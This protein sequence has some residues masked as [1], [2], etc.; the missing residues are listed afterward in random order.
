M[1]YLRSES[2]YLDEHLQHTKPLQEKLFIEMKARI[3]ENDSTVPEKRGGYFYYSRYLAGKQYPI[4]CRKQGSLDGVEEILL[5]QNELAEGKLFCSVGAF[6]ISPD[7]SKFVYSVDFG[8]QEIYRLHI[9]D[10]QNGNLSPEVID[11][12]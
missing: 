6:S 10:L 4:F 3:K 5:D 2:D 12:I 11:N 7:E 1:K 8:G 9:K